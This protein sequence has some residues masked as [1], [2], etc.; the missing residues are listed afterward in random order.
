M[1]RTL[2]RPALRQF[3]GHAGRGNVLPVGVF[4]R[5]GRQGSLDLPPHSAHGDSK[6][7]LASADEIDDFIGT[8]ALIN[9]RAVAHQGDARKVL[10]FPRSKV[11][12][13]DANVLQGDTRINESLH[14]AKDQDV[15]ETVQALS[16]GAGRSPDR[17]GHQARTRPVIQL[18]IG[19][20][21]RG[22]RHGTPVTGVRR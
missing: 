9:A 2:P 11:I 5:E 16:A 13:R 12:Y 14:D 17:R 3:V 21:S 22:T 6:H 10:T 18:S 7:A 19:D 4:G 20:T 1:G 8:A 15:A